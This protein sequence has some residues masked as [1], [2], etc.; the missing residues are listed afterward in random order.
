MKVKSKTPAKKTAK[1]SFKKIFAESSLFKGKTVKNGVV[2]TAKSPYKFKKGDK[3]QIIV[4]H[5]EIKPNEVITVMENSF[6]PLCKTKRGTIGLDQNYLKLA[7]K[8]RTVLTITTPHGKVKIVKT[9]E[10]QFHIQ[11]KANNNEIV[12]HSEVLEAKQTGIENI[13]VMSKIYGSREMS[14]AVRKLMSKNKQSKK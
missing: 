2:K 14:E 6:Y 13:I 9:D 7:T 1:K 4:P 11:S 10:N 5:H 8:P 3:V 12:Q